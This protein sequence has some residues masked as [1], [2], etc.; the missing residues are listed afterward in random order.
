MNKNRKTLTR[1]K[2]IEQIRIIL[3]TK[4]Y[5]IRTKEG[6]NKEVYIPIMNCDFYFVSTYKSILGSLKKEEI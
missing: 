3:R 2:H 4:H 5:S 1:Q 6:I